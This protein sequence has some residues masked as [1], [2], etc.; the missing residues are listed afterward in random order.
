MAERRRIR[1]RFMTSFEF[2]RIFFETKRWQGLPPKRRAAPT[3]APDEAG[4]FA[5]DG[6]PYVN[7]RCASDAAAV[8]AMRGAAEQSTV[9][10][11]RRASAAA[12]GGACERV[13]VGRHVA[14]RAGACDTPYPSLPK[15]PM[16][17][18]IDLPEDVAQRAAMLVASGRFAS[19]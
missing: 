12:G 15:L 17:H 10:S 2:R 19:V 3:D 8:R 9:E 1:R 18:L 4:Y 6:R 14:L 7:T 5:P 13:P 11:S 16:T